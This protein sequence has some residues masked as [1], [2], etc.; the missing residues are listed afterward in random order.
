MAD[1][2]VNGLSLVICVTCARHEDMGAGGGA[3]VSYRFSVFFI[4]A[5]GGGGW[6]SSCFG[7]FS[8]QETA[9]GPD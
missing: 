1:S 2:L 6:L 4:S 5:L 3:E 7:R 9:L 8:S